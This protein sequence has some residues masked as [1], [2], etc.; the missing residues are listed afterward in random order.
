MCSQTSRQFSSIESGCIP[1]SLLPA[2][3]SQDGK[4]SGVH[5]R[6]PSKVKIF[7]WMLTLDRP[8]TRQNLHRKT[9]I[10]DQACLRCNVAVE[11]TNHMFFSCPHAAAVWHS[12]GFSPA[13]NPLDDIWRSTNSSRTTSLN[14]HLHHSDHFMENL[15][16][17]QHKRFSCP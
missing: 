7:G 1:I 11:D 13:S 16:R 5:V 4:F 17:A 8:N 10:S 3:G 14:H 12:I 6:T 2:G 9:I 15:S